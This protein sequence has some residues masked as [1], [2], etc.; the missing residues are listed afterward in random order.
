LWSEGFTVDGGQLRSYR[1]PANAPFLDAVK[2]GEVPRELQEKLQGKECSLSI[3]DKHH[4]DYAPPKNA[5]RAFTGKGQMLGSPAPVVSSNGPA[6]V[7]DRQTTESEARNNITLAPG[8]PVTTIQFR[9]VDGSRLSAQFNHNHTV[10]DLYAFINAARPEYTGANYILTLFPNIQLT[11]KAS[12]LKQA[13]I[14]NS[15]LTQ[16]IQSA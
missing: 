11:E 9:L 13:N 16:K 14:L 7:S 3:I 6:S 1:D 4:E 5:V 2:R 15:A 10:E 8:E 12:S